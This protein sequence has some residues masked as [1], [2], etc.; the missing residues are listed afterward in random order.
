MPLRTDAFELSG[1]H[2]HSGE[3][4][5]LEL[6]VAI[7]PFELGG[8]RY[9]IGPELIPAVLDVS[10]TTGNGYAL[11]LRFRVTVSGPCMR[12]LEAADP[13]FDV[14]AREVWQPGGGE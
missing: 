7:D 14:D 1:L 11:R 5:R 6:A 13:S 4:R 9:S 10:R 3:G 12:C 8:E 2:L